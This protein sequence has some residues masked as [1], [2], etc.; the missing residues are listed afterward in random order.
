ARP[1]RG[2][3]SA[4]PSGELLAGDREEE[5]FEAALHGDEG[6]DVDAGAEQ[7]AGEGRHGDAIQR[8]PHAAVFA[9]AHDTHASDAPERGPERGGVGRADVDL[10]DGALARDQLAHGA[11]GDHRPVLHDAHALAERLDLREEVRR[12][13]DGE[14]LGAGEVGEHVA[15]LLHAARV[16]A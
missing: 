15:H 10:G 9:L 4:G 7:R 13:E 8:D 3:E 1:G 16:Q 5:V 11:L 12:D 6:L 14:L 2:G